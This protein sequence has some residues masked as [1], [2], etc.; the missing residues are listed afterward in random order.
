MCYCI[1]GP[2][3]LITVKL[4]VVNVPDLNY[5]RIHFV[6]QVGWFSK[7]YCGLSALTIL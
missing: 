1:F 2:I 3:R 4:V 5:V 6:K 7:M